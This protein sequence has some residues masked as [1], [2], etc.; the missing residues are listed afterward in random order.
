MMKS[1]R[2]KAE[3]TVEAKCIVELNES[4]Q[5]ELKTADLTLIRTYIDEEGFASFMGDI[6]YNTEA[7]EILE[8]EEIHQATVLIHN[9]LKGLN[10][11]TLAAFK[12]TEHEDPELV[13]GYGMEDKKDYGK[14]LFFDGNCYIQHWMSSETTDPKFE[15][16]V[17]L[18]NDEC[19]FETKDAAIRYLYHEHY[20]VEHTD[21][22]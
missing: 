3:Y 20:L 16:T 12:A 1:Y 8:Y 5:E 9:D 7:Y 17:H 22:F 21:L 2:F 6:I 14:V 18:M 4:Q 15:W 11:M 13:L 10:I 19:G